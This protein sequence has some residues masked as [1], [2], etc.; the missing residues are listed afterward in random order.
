MQYR[1]L[2]CSFEFE[3]EGPTSCIKCGNLYIKWL[4]YTEEDPLEL[5]L[6][7]SPILKFKCRPVEEKEFGPQLESFCLQ[8]I[9][10]MKGN[11]GIGLAANQVGNARRIIVMKHDDDKYI[12][13]INPVII[14]RSKEQCKEQEGC[15]S[16][17]GLYEMIDR[18]KSVTVE[19]FDSFGLK[20][21]ETFHNIESICIQHEID[22]LDGLTFLDRMSRLKKQILLKKMSKR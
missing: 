22:H 13:L 6:Y 19:Y 9:N 5:V 14:D 20:K 15:L 3:H 21:T 4:D 10:V 7:P 8:M 12:S 1:C 16:F 11:R 2:K 17:P 18:N